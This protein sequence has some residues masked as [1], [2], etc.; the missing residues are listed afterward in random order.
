MLKYFLLFVLFVSQHVIG[1]DT[2]IKAGCSKDYPGVKWFIYED[3]EGSR[4]VTK[5]VR[6][7][8]C[9]FNRYLNLSMEKASGDRFNPAI[10]TVDYKDMLGRNEPWGMVHHSTTIGTASFY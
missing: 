5:D 7:W 10:V 3:A 8:E 1:A 6:S 4:Y 9:G 2:L